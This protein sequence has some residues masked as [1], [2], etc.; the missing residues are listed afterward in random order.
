MKENFK[1]FKTE[2]GRRKILS[3]YSKLL[4]E[5][6]FT[7]RERYVDTAFGKTYVLESGN[8][9]KPPVVLIH[10][11]CS[12]SAAWFRDIPVLA[13]HYHVYSVD[14]VGDAGSSEENRLDQFTNEFTDWLKGVFDGLGIEKAFLM[15]NSLGGWISLKFAAA[16]P[17]RVAKLALIAPAGIAPTKGSFVFKSLIYLMAG[18]KGRNAISRMIFGKDDIPGEVL[19][20]INMIAD[21][22]NPL[23]GA[24][25]SLTDD[26]MKKLTMPLLYIAGENDAVIDTGKSVKR[27]KKMIPG[28]SIHVIKNNGHVILDSLQWAMPFLLA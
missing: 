13:E 16:Y 9:D 26:Q 20:F 7:Y 14:V 5:V 21:N 11:S 1:V 17:D 15:G 6:G 18:E 3:Y 22:F 27:L 28:A 19:Y 12:N 10:G 2:E 23:T 25:P 24:L 8:P 4:G